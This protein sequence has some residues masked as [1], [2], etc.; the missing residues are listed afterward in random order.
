MYTTAESDMF[1]EIREIQV[2]Q[3]RKSSA[4]CPVVLM[5]ESC[6][7]ETPL[8]YY[9]CCG[10]LN[11][12]CCFRLQDWVIVLLIILAV[13]IILSIVVNFLRCLFCYGR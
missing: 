3:L 9:K 1:E 4:G 12:S 6:P 13:C 2:F 5:G 11:T 8:Y 10:Q 7:E